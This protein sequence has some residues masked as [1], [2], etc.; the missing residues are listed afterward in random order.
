MPS[1]M[2]DRN[3]PRVLF[4]TIVIFFILWISL[5]PQS[6]HDCCSFYSKFFITALFL[7][8][9]IYK[10]DVVFLFYR[11]NIFLWLFLGWQIFS[12]LFAHDRQA[13]WQRY[14]DFVTPFGVLYFVFKEELNPAKARF[15]LF[16][17]FFSAIAVSAIGILEFVFNKSIIYE[18]FIKN[19]FY[20]RYIRE[21]RIMSTMMSPVISGTYLMS[22]L[23]ASYYVIGA[24]NGK[25]KRLFA[26]SGMVIIITGLILTFTRTSWLA[27]LIITILYVLRK[28][29]KLLL[30]LIFSCFL[31][32]SSLAVAVKIRPV[33]AD[34][35]NYKHFINYLLEGHRL[36]RYPVTFKMAKDHP[37]SGVGLN[38]YRIVFDGYYGRKDE[39]FEF[40]IPD[41]MYLMIIGESGVV[42][43]GLFV[44][45]IFFIL[46]KA[47]R[48]LRRNK[49]Q[50]EQLRLAFF[51][52]LIG[53]LIHMVSYELFYWVTPFFLFL[54]SLGAVSG[55]LGYKN[56]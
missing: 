25:I 13:A 35:V 18:H 54:L 41:N 5:T 49:D 36:K 21:S 23:P 1:M 38:N 28:N 16:A 43:F 33:L 8:W 55:N 2:E 17:L 29:I 7:I 53:L 15:I 6:I 3:V 39:P 31:I 20:A 51:L 22:C 37:I 47:I 34:R 56:D 27:A 11:E 44:T 48:D 50:H 42:G 19:A 10:K 12:V 30:I 9:L 26:V 40:K 45:L 46:K 24:L 32:Y 52:M 14:A 4:C